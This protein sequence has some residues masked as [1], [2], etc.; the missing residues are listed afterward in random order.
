MTPEAVGSVLHLSIKPLKS[1]G[2]RLL[3]NEAR[4]TPAGLETVDGRIRDHDFMLVEAEPDAMGIHHFVHQRQKG[5]GQMV[6]IQPHLDGKQLYVDWKGVD[7]IEIPLD[8]SHGPE[9]PVQIWDDQCMAFDHGDTLASWFTKHLNHSVRLVQAKGPNFNRQARQ[10]YY[11]NKNPMRFQDGGPIHWFT[12]EDVEELEEMAGVK[13]GWERFG[14]QLVAQGFP[15]QMIHAMLK[16]TVGEVPMV[17]GWPCGRCPIPQRDQD[18]GEKTA[19]PNRTLWQYKAY[20]LDG[21]PA[22]M[23]G[24]N[25]LPDGEGVVRVGDPIEVVDWRNEVVVYDSLKNIRSNN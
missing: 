17:N 14:P 11:S 12:I 25:G 16:V 2:G 9:I 15:P 7:A 23:F 6:H 19:E 8:V 13:L 10:K 21:N 1:S 22:V 18:S 4:I 24:E 5:M 20:L 3:V